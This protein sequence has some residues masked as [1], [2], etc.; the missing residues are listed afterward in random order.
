MGEIADDMINGVTC[1]LCGVYLGGEPVGFPAF[2]SRQCAKDGGMPDGYV[3][4]EIEL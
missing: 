2:C 4:D 3:A 1:N